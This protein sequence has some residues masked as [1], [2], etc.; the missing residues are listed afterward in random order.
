MSERC[1]E[2]RSRDLYKIESLVLL[3]S[4]GGLLQKGA[5]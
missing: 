3:L 5:S 2:K 1:K 4:I